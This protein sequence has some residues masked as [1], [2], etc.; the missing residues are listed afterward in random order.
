MAGEKFPLI[1]YVVSP[2]LTVKIQV[3]S[4]A[5]RWAGS[6]VLAEDIADNEELKAALYEKGSNAYVKIL[7]SEDAEDI[8][9]A[10]TEASTA[11]DD[12]EAYDDLVHQVVAKR[13]ELESALLAKLNAQNALDADAENETLIDA[14]AAET[15]KVSTIETALAALEAQLITE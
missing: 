3:L 10:L 8:A 6:V 12:A 11:Q 4:P 1:P 13:A 9:T 15:T 2:S 7:F 14:L 5:V